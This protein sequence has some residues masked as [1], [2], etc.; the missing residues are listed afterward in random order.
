[1][2]WGNHPLF[3][4]LASGSWALIAITFQSISPS[5]IIAKMP[6][7]FTWITWPGEHTW[8]TDQQKNSQPQ[9]EV[10]FISILI[11]KSDQKNIKQFEKKEFVYIW[12][13]YLGADLTDVNRIIIATTLCLFVCVV[14]VFPCL[15]Q[16]TDFKTI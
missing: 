12:G 2:I 5:S 16:E 6:S 3:K 4:L 9:N 11:F 7:T 13:S 10:L 8:R 14:W 15:L 1:M